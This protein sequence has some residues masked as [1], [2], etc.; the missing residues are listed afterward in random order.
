VAELYNDPP[1]AVTTPSAGIY[2]LDNG[3]GEIKAMNPAHIIYECATNKIWGRGMPASLIDDDSFK[4]AAFKLFQENFGLCLRWNRTDDID[5]F[6]KLVCD[7]I[8]AAVYFDR[9]TGLLTLKL[10]RND[11]TVADLPVFDFSNGLLDITDDQVSS[12]QTL[13]NEI[14]VSFNDPLTDKVGEVRVQNLASYQ[15]IGTM[16]S[17]KVEY[18]G[19]ATASLALRLAQRDLE[20]NSSELRRFKLKFDRRAWKIAPSQP[21]CISAPSRGIDNIVVRAGNIEDSS[22][23][24]GT[25]TID[26]V[27][28]VFGL[29]D[30]SFTQP[31]GSGWRPPDRT[32]RIITPRLV[33][34][35]TYVDTSLLISSAELPNVA[36]DNGGVK[37]FAEQPTNTSV[38]FEVWSKA[39]GE[40]DMVF[41]SVGGWDYTST[42]TDDIGYYDTILPIDTVPLSVVTG[43]IV[44]IDDEYMELI[45]INDDDTIEVSRGCI[46]TLPAQ[47]LKGAV[48]WYQLFNPTS[49]LRTYSL[50]ETVYVMLLTRTSSAV[51][52]SDLAPTDEVG[53]QGRQGKPYPP[54]NM[55]VNGEPVYTPPHI[56]PDD[57]VFTWAHRDRVVQGDT[58]LDHSAA[59]TGPEP[60]TTYTIRVYDEPGTTLLRTFTGV[61]DDTWTYTPAMAA[62]DGDLRGYWFEVESERDGYASWQHY[63]FKVVRTTGFDEDFD[64]YFDGSF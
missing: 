35:L 14:I 59:S 16:I 10:I 51:L 58:L 57:I 64:Y 28:D 50:G 42:L 20:I 38:D 15:A 6:I 24:D 32:P 62:A 37:I 26:A 1:P 53:I 52:E 5:Q 3:T 21:F 36:A 46:D 22:L 40:T 61:T 39:E 19:A 49:D 11:Y 18:L 55:M 44:L 9:Q 41:R 60:G 47:H 33:T 34:E 29:P 27:Q 48:V 8:G 4:D 7:H 63:R 45:S 43:A 54:G 12:S 30:A 25:I 13:Y 17:N 23:E 56:A 2:V 31:Q